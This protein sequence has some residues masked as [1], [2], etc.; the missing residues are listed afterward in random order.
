MTLA[1]SIAF[2]IK[3]LTT[4]KSLM[5]VLSNMYEKPSTANKKG[6][7][8][9]ISSS[10]AKSKLKYDEVISMILTE[11]MRIQSNN[12]STSSLGLNMENPGKGSGHR[13]SNNRGRSRTKRVWKAMVRSETSLR[14]KKLKTDNGGEYEDTGFK[15]FCYEDGIKMEKTVSGT[16][17]HNSVAEWMNRTLTERVRS[18][19]I[20][21]NLPLQFWAEAVGTTAYLINRGPSVP[22][23]HRIPEELS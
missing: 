20:Q 5:D 1:K 6:I 11:E 22:L 2:N 21:S 14:I 13:R 8:T 7:V 19:R 12:A 18:M 10:I 3:H 9:A 23:D 4:T 15:T 17:Q 16:P